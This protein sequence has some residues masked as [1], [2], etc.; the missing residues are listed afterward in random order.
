ML[1]WGET[2]SG[3]V[4]VIGRKG[5]FILF[6]GRLKTPDLFSDFAVTVQRTLLSQN[7]WL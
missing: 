1:L 3:W 5:S 4:V 2:Y 7:S 6:S